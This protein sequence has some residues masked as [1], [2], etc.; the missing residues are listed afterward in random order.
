MCSIIMLQGCEPHQ[1]SDSSVSNATIL[2]MPKS[3]R[4][5][6]ARNSMPIHGKVDITAVESIPAHYHFVNA[7]YFTVAVIAGNSPPITTLALDNKTPIGIEVDV[8]RLI[9][10]SLG[11]QLKLVPTSWEDW[12]LGINSGKYDAA[13]IN[14]SV[15]KA[16][17]E[18]F[19]FVTY[20]KDSLGLFVAKDSSI[21]H[22]SEAKDVAGQRVIVGAGTNQ[23]KILLR[24][25]DENQKQGLATT[26]PVYFED[27]AMAILA[28]ESGR[29]DVYFVPNPSGTWRMENG[30]R[31]KRVGYLNGGWPKTADIAVTLKKGT[32]LDQAIH[33]AVNA[34]IQNGNMHT[35]LARWGLVNEVLP[36]SEINPSGFGE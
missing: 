30:A 22:I 13:L 17:K 11:L 3:M 35:V 23:E 12:P 14:I 27:K 31:I 21:Q 26:T 1:S 32:G 7:G 25:I 36:Y 4:D 10:D 2:T 6:L 16:R 19:D 5:L 18:R 29:A 33:L 15:S 28:I 9:A 8:A 34:N 24:W 20:R